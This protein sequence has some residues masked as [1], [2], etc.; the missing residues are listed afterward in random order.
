MPERDRVPRLARPFVAT[1]LAAMVLCATFAV[2]PWPLTSFKLFSEVRTD[3]RTAW[4]AT[5]IDASGE[6]ATYPLGAL[7]L[8]FRGFGFTM[9][10]FVAAD[11]ERQAELC[12]TWIDAADELVGREAVGVRI[13]QRSWRLSERSGDRAD[14]GTETVAHVCTPTG[15]EVAG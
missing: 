10:E 14:P 6:E 4:R 12:R 13:Y 1:L 3:E 5:T 2:E 11:S 15:A 7:P 9:S 8:G